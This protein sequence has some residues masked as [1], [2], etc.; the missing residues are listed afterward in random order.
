[1]P[2][3]YSS[4]QI[5]RFA[6]WRRETLRG[7]VQTRKQH[8]HGIPPTSPSFETRIVERRNKV[9]HPLHPGSAATSSREPSSNPGPS[10]LHPSFTPHSTLQHPTTPPPPHLHTHRTSSTYPPPTTTS[11]PHLHPTPTQAQTPPARRRK[12]ASLAQSGIPLGRGLE[13]ANELPLTNPTRAVRVR[14]ADELRLDE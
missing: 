10:T 7:S 3:I 2:R 4:L 6:G 11:S 5:H 9:S 12:T 1:M 14:N 13:L 8:E